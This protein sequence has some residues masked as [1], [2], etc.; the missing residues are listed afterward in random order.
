MLVKLIAAVQP[1]SV[2]HITAV[3]MISGHPKNVQ[4]QVLH[5]KG[6]F[7]EKNHTHPSHGI[8]KIKFSAS[9]R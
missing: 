2:T 6:P 3:L 8:S 5:Q 4:I 1:C 9:R 7:I